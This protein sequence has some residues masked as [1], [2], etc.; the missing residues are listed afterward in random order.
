MNSLPLTEISLCSPFIAPVM[1]NS[2]K[3]MFR[4]KGFSNLLKMGH[5]APAVMQ[6]ILDLDK[7]KK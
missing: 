1:S 3:R 4:R 6:P 2:I 5:C 7:K